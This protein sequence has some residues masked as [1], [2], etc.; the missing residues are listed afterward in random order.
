MEKA[1]TPGTRTGGRAAGQGAWRR[2]SPAAAGWAL[3][4]LALA[5]APAAVQGTW[6]IVAMDRE[7]GQVVIASATC[8]S[9]EVLEGFPAQGLRDIQAIVVPGAGGAV[10]QAGVDRT[11]QNQELIHRH[12]ERGTHPDSI[13]A[14]L[15][16]DP[17]IDHRQ[18]AVVD[19]QGRAATFTGAENGQAALAVADTTTD[20]SVT[21]S[22]QGNILASD[23]VVTA[24]VEAFHA[25]E[26]TLADR[27]MAAMEAADVEGG[28]RRC[29]CAT[30][31]VP[32]APCNGRSAH[33]AYLMVVEEDDVTGDDP[34]DVTPT[35]LVDVTD[36][37]IE[38]HE[39]ANPVKTLRMR[40]DALQGDSDPEDGEGGEPA[41]R[42]SYAA[43]SP[44][45]D[46]FADLAAFTDLPAEPR[47]T[48]SSAF[49]DHWGD[50]R[51]ELSGYRLEVRRY[52]EMRNGE[53]V[54][55]YVTEPHDRRTW[56][57]DDHVQDPH[58]VEVLK[59]L[60][61]RTFDTGIYPYTV[62]SGVF[63]PVD[64][65]R[66][67]PFQ[68][69]RVELDAQEWCGSESHRVWVGPDR[70][71]SLRL[72]YF[73][74][75][76]ESLREVEASEGALYEDALLVQLRELDGSFAGG[77]DWEG[78][79]VPDL[80]LLRAELRSAEPLEAS[81]TRTEGD[82]AGIPVTRFRIQ[83][84]LDGRTYERVFEVERDAPRRVLTWTTR[85][86]GEVVER[87]EILETV[88]LPYWELNRVGDE[89]YRERLGLDRSGA[90]GAGS[91]ASASGS[92]APGTAGS[93]GAANPGPI[94]GSSCGP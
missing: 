54:T 58:R 36:R 27:T 20:G 92:T 80:W 57:K 69:V 59:L 72:S 82:R 78:T 28:D 19:R 55:V 41:T 21:F 56:V 81:I 6:S 83:A 12:L 16:E 64:R 42:P 52:G 91:G 90:R 60:A 88:R 34:G 50:G 2:R 43:S 10:A 44:A 53:L 3:A 7:S 9:Q 75:P 15:H 45:D 31:P 8:V 30:E 26:G 67:E 25:Q 37:N 23:E 1:P 40:Y 84:P 11:R 32:G 24:A 5:L 73:D 33:V 79:L 61:S 65:W 39:N 29:D 94:G 14:M 4:V 47:A 71:R 70:Y 46:P 76:G 13:I 18:F 86:D 35:L 66:D 77:G 68:P 51:A 49:W 89:A 17:R 85:I 63:S 48:A 87:A 74:D 22:V 93:G 62:L 38:P